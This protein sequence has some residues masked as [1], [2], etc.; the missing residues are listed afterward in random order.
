MN[1][2]GQIKADIDLKKY[3]ET[4]EGHNFKGSKT[5]C[6]FHNDHEPSMDVNLVN[7]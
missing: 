2:I 6:P 7:G 3:L 4:Y 1:T 5:V